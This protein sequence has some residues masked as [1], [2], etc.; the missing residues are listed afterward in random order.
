M[1]SHTSHALQALDRSIFGA[2]KK[3]V[4]KILAR[5]QVEHQRLDLSKWEIPNLFQQAWKEAACES[6]A[7]MHVILPTP[8]GPHCR[9]HSTLSHC[10]KMRLS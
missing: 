8:Q 5:Y 6:N 2:L 3:L 10:N 7:A 4:R 1:P 9:P